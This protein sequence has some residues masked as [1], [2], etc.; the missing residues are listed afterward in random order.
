MYSPLC[1]LCV[2]IKYAQ[3][4]H[5]NNFSAMPLRHTEMAP[6]HVVN[7]TRCTY[8]TIPFGWHSRRARIECW[9]ASASLLA[10]T[11]EGD[12]KGAGIIL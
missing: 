9:I 1:I 12:E 2:F 11:G 5:V 3:C 8:P 10:L 6:S 4:G 7:G